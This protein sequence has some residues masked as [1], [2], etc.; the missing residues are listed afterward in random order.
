MTEATGDL[1]RNK[2]A[3]KITKAASKTTH[4]YPSKSLAQI[5]ETLTQSTGI[6]KGKCILTERRQQIIDEFHFL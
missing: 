5:D 4:D 3:Q 2:I 1:V 6:P